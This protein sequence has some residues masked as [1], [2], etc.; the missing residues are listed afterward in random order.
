MVEAETSNTADT[1]VYGLTIASEIHKTEELQI[2]AITSDTHQSNADD[3][4]LTAKPVASKEPPSIFNDNEPTIV[5]P[6]LTQGHPL[7]KFLEALPNILESTSYNEI[8]GI[9]LKVK[10]ECSRPDFHTLLILQKF[11]RANQNN[12]TK[13]KE[14]LENTLRWRKQFDPKA[15][16]TAVYDKGKYG[17]LGY[18]VVVPARDGSIPPVVTTWNI[19]GSVKDYEKT[20]VPVEDFLRWRVGLMEAGV[21]R[22]NLSSASVPIPDY[23]QG[24]DPYQGIQIHD[25]KNVS[26]FKMDARAKAA[27]KATI[28]LLGNYYPETLSRKFFVNIPSIMGWLY[29]GMKLLVSAETTKKFVVLSDGLFIAEELGETVPNEYGGKLG[30]LRKLGEEMRLE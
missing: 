19:Y 13:A 7:S 6:V 21:A 9:T 24:E 25:Y 4:V 26:F 10:K 11:L 12:F 30:E 17:G 16:A 18:I 28:E 15:A 5:W 27:S 2:P 3:T 8:Y 29:A 23:G 14:Q 1:P 20:F 22:L